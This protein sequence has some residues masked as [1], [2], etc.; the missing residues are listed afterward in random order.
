[1]RAIS[2]SEKP[3]SP[4]RSRA[5]P[6]DEL[7]RARAG[8][9]AGGGDA[10]RPPRAVGRGRRRPVERVDLLRGDPAHGR[11]LVLGV[12]GGDVDLRALCALA[13]ADDLR[14]PLGQDLGAEHGRAEHHL[15]DG[16]VD[17]LLEAAHVRALLARAEVD[18][19][20]QRRGEQV[21][22]A[23]VVADADDL[24]HAGHAHT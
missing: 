4:S 13:L 5:L 14:D 21:L 3:S 20:V 7:L 6:G 10:H 24:L 16:V 15:A 23:V 18:E 11:G 2:S 19:A 12:A 8:G 17:D 22:A 1:M 9:D